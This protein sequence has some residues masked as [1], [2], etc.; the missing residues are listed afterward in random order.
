MEFWAWCGLVVL[1]VL[2]SNFIS[3]GMAWNC[4]VCMIQ[5][6]VS[7]VWCSVSMVWGCRDGVEFVV[8]VWS[9]K[10]CGVTSKECNST[11]T[12]YGVVK[13]AIYNGNRL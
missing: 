5:S 2:D 6:G 10:T 8:V 13:W 1:C 11:S 12:L 3:T 7:M 4:G 9:S